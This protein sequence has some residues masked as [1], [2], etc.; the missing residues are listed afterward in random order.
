M[1]LERR[2]SRVLSGDA[3]SREE[4]LERLES[5]TRALS[6]VTHSDARTLKI[7]PDDFDLRAMLDTLRVRMDDNG[8]GLQYTGITFEGLTTVGVDVSTQHAES[9]GE[10][11]RAIAT[12]PATIAASRKPK[13]RN[14]IQGVDGLIEPGE[15]LLVLGRPGSGCTSFLR[16][17]AGEIDNFV[18]VE[19]K[20]LYDG[21]PL[22]DML[23]HFKDEIIY[24]PELDVHF[25][26]IT[27][28]QT[29]RF[30]VASKTPEKRLPGVSRKK[31]QDSMVEL[32]AT[33]FGL[34]HALQTKVGNDYVRGVS[35]GERKRVSIA[36]ALAARGTVY[37]W[38][39]ATRGLDASTALEYNQAIRATTNFLNNIAVV[40]IYQAGEN[41]YQLY[42]KVTVLYNGR[43]VYFGPAKDARQYFINQGWD[44]PP[45][46][47][48]AE[49]LTAVTDPNGRTPREGFENKVPRTADEFVD[50]WKR[51]P[52]YAKLMQDIANY[53]SGAT[54]RATIDRFKTIQMDQKKQPRQRKAS[55]Y[56]LRYHN[57]LLLTA[58]R[59]FQRV[60]GDKAYTV[61]NV[62]GAIIQSLIMGS[63]FYNIDDSTVGAFSRGGVIFFA[64]LYNS[65]ASLA[66]VSHAFENRPILL[67]Q[68]GYSF[69]HPSAEALQKV[70][71]DL[72]VKAA[73]LIVFSIVLYFLSQLKQTAGQFF[74]FLLILL[75]TV[76][77]ISSFFNALAALTKSAAPANAL[78]GIGV[79]ILS[80]Y[81]GYMIPT[82]S[83]HPWFRWLNWLDPLAYGFE[84]LMGNEFHGRQM[85]CTQLVPSG[86][87]Y[88]NVSFENQVC[89][90][91]GSIPGNEFVSG[92]NYLSVAY[93][94]SWSHA[95]RNFG[96]VIGFWIFFLGVGALF[97]EFLRPMSGGG[98]VLLFKRGHMPE[99]LE[100][101][102]TANAEELEKAL[103]NSEDLA[104]KDVFT[105]QHVDYVIPL[106]GS[107]RKL[108]DDVQGY[109]KPGTMTALMGE[110]GAGKTTLLNVLSQRIH[111]GT[112][113]GDMLV[114]GRPL[115]SSFQR[116]TGYVQQQDLHL[117]E[118][119]VRESLQFAARLRQPAT[120]PDAEKLDYVEK[121]IKL[122]GMSD[123]AE[124][125]VGKAGRGLN[126]EQRKKLSIGV[127][128]VAKPS[129]LLFLDEPTSGLDSQSSWAIVQFLRS[130]AR[131]GQSILCTI[132]QPSATLFEQFDRLLL[133]K[134]GGKTVYFGDIGENSSTLT[135]YFERQGAR[136]CEPQEN[137]AEY[138]LEM[139][140][141]GATAAVH[142]DWYEKWTASR[143]FAE[144]TAEIARL[145][146][147]LR[148]RP[149]APGNEKELTKKYAAPYYTQFKYVYLRTMKQY[150][151]T[152]SYIMAKFF[153]MVIGGLF[154]G[155]T[156]WNVGY[157]LSGLQN[158]MFGIFLIQVLSAPLTNQIQANAEDSRELFEVRE[159]ASNT[160]H[161]SCLLLAQFLAEL[162]YHLVFSTLLYCCFYFPVKY[163]TS[164]QIAGYFYFIYC[165]VF[166][167][168]YVSF[169]LWV[170]Y[171]SP[172]A[173]SA[174]VIS[175]LLF[176]FMIA[177][178]GVLQPVSQMPGFWT[179]MYKVSPYTYF[180]QSYM[181]I[182]FHGRAVQCEP[183][184]FQTLQP[185]SGQ[186]CGEY[187]QTYLDTM[188]GY[189]NNP[190]AT[191]NCQYCTYDIG[192][193]YLSTLGISYSYK[194]RNVG[195]MFA[196]IVFNLCAMLV[197]YYLFRVKVWTTPKIFE[198][199]K[200]KKQED[201]P[202]PNV[203]NERAGDE[204]YLQPS[205]GSSSVANGEEP[206][207][208]PSADV[209]ATT[210]YDGPAN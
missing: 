5:V 115:D 141:A 91:S 59:G 63:L 56:L 104:A 191:S 86:P 127:E 88:E 165:I 64:L 121:I 27:V 89:A 129:L 179:F 98:D 40:A 3:A 206:L 24:N 114:N 34:R 26:H 126:V 80:V 97:T 17:V 93:D 4:A 207:M 137:P 196:Y 74:F 175:S 57:Q 203:Y 48:T 35:G 33:V 13:L 158:A 6:R 162:P 142:E 108:L 122:L 208:N 187:M 184:E 58:K 67:K 204:K 111:F 21:A 90:F 185:P 76:M 169:A 83:M 134:K 42:D 45:R 49:F 135:S 28:D 77:C 133:L 55:R 131:A 75:V 44:C 178:C 155:F 146:E 182:T 163:D 168:Y 109:V 52:E 14:I 152:P 23:K 92:D 95:W 117:A 167:L 51:S 118:S 66:E 205:T 36:E 144:V 81:T 180:I 103:S 106:A 154:I 84:S 11:V 148:A 39:N 96:I 113:T 87:G 147:D 192:D 190:D 16:T 102:A 160:F 29:L 65:L 12:L 53:N 47:T 105:W 110:S 194:W 132:H 198:M 100:E 199:F 18:S 30:A 139:I 73:T 46:Q 101:H 136:K 79:L 177:F 209:P 200:K 9:V 50:Y 125:M 25:P 8:L 112:I 69:Y 143:E 201:A 174:S 138:I 171:F 1:A 41:I 151:R 37:C 19:G 107:T 170:V 183:R 72:P 68:K 15:M 31:Y 82:T 2:V 188:T 32:L 157:S 149:A 172:D 7:D 62:I 120:T 166:Q 181:L 156:F 123:Y 61:T 10:V 195:L 43:Q 99:T 173:A 54:A 130:L 159:S 176:S 85:P 189:I 164:P 60:A 210:K 116:R 20:L 197:F 193:Q 186:T 94:Y 202:A 145:N 22:E 150:W 70:L 38:D 78:A 71:T 124:A 153:L 140:G 119:T 161:W 128:L